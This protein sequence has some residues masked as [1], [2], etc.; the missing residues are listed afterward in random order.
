ME[1]STDT[2]PLR[3]GSTPT[4]STNQSILALLLNENKF[5]KQNLPTFRNA[6]K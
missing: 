2:D 1:D 4:K 3:L 5:F 6:T